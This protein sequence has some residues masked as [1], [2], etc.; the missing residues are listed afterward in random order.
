MPDH[1]LDRKNPNS[2]PEYYNLM[3]E[4]LWELT[5]EAQRE[6]GGST[7]YTSLVRLRLSSAFKMP[8]QQVIAD[9]LQ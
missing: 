2:H 9:G 4:K 6:A 1:V 8:L 5:K 3:S 7:S